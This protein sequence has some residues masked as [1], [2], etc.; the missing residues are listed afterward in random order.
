MEILFRESTTL[1]IRF[2]YS[3]RKVLR[4]S[5]V[6]VESPW[7]KIKV[8]QAVNSDGSAFFLPEYE[9]CREIALKN[10]LPLKEIFSWVMSLNK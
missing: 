5:V 9:V 6:E 2:R 1:G 10:N 4:R 7:G 3:Q 8:K